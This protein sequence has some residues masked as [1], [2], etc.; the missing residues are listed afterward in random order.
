MDS[1]AVQFRNG[2]ESIELKVPVEDVEEGEGEGEGGEGV[3]A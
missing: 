1:D 3:R 2:H